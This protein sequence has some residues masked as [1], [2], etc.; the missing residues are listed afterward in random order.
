MPDIDVLPANAETI[1]DPTDD[2]AESTESAP[3]AAES[4]TFSE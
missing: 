2:P 1:P 4:A 3:D